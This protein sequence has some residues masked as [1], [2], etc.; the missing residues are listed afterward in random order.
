[1]A[2][3][4]KNAP[5][6]KTHHRFFAAVLVWGTLAA[7]T[8]AF[9][10]ELPDILIK[11]SQLRHD[12]V[13]TEDSWMYWSV[14]AIYGVVAA[15]VLWLIIHIGMTARVGTILALTLV[16]FALVVIPTYSRMWILQILYDLLQDPAGYSNSTVSSF[17]DWLLEK[18]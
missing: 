16:L 9:I 12:T 18:Y 6:W 4:V 8:V 3:K 17:F 2:K 1:M 15:L 5:K 10:H 14:P 7:F 13:G 11:L